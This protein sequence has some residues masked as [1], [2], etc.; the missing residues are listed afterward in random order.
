MLCKPY[1]RS[2]FDYYIMKGRGRHLLHVLKKYFPIVIIT[3][4]GF[5]IYITQNKDQSSERKVEHED[6]LQQIE[7]VNE[8]EQSAQTN[9]I[10]VSTDEVIVDIK[11]A[12]K[13]PGVYEVN[14][15]SRIHNVIELAGGFTEKADEKQINLAQKVHDEMV[16]YV[17]KKGEIDIPITQSTQIGQ[18]S[19]EGMDKIRLN[20]ATAEELTKLNGIGPAKA[21]AIINHREEHGPFMQVE[22]LLQVNGIGEKTLE[23]IRDNIIIP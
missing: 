19:T 5:V 12:I 7:M 15:N 22:D 3:V 10:N 4:I 17:P 8:N 23:N 2:S 18:S 6:F 14:K 9:E 16:I 21:E 11:G 13:H 20:S 1:K